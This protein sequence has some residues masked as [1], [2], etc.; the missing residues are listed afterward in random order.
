[1]VRPAASVPGRCRWSAKARTSDV[2][3][4]E[5]PRL[6]LAGPAWR[7]AYPQRE[8]GDVVVHLALAEL[9]RHL[10]EPG[11]D[12]A[13]RP[14]GQRPDLTLQLVVEV[15]LARA[16]G[17]GEPVAVEDEGVARGQ[18]V[19]LQ[20]GSGIGEDAERQPAPPELAQLA[21]GAEQQRG[22]VAGAAEHHLQRP[23]PPPQVGGARG[24]EAA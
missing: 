17:V 2:A 19:P 13:R 7:F 20:P 1:M 5:G 21:V 22:W 3:G 11:Q 4:A 23:V 8:H 14:P 12:L 24:D 9:Q 18:F 15:T 6:G 10:L 16:V